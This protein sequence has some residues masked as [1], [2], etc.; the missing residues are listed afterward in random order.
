VVWGEYAAFAASGYVIPFLKSGKL[1]LV[2][3]YMCPP[4]GSACS[5]TQ[6][7]T[8]IFPNP[9]PTCTEVCETTITKIDDNF[10]PEP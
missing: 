2:H 3:A 9:I 7:T 5:N 1:T 4:W 6:I 10:S 8:Q